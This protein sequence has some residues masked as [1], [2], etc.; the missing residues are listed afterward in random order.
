VDWPERSYLAVPQISGQ[1]ALNTA[2]HGGTGFR[3]EKIPT[4]GG[5]GMSTGFSS[6]IVMY[7]GS[8]WLRTQDERL[9]RMVYAPC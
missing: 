2:I 9:T 8:G 6:Y 3:K 1:T 4:M 5:T 7:Y